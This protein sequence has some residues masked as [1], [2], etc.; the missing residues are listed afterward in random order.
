MTRL[1]TCA[2]ALAA[3]W[4]L[5]GCS[6]SDD[7]TPDNGVADIP[8][9]DES[10]ADPGVADEGPA[11]PGTPDEGPADPGTP[12]VP[13]DPGSDPGLP[14][15][16]D[17]CAAGPDS[18]PNPRLMGPFPVGIRTVT[19]TDPNNPNEDGSPRILKTEIWYPTTEEYRDAERY[20]YD[21]KADGT[22]AMREKYADIDIGDFPCDGVYDAPVRRGSGRFPL[23]VFSHGA[24][25]IRFQSVFYT[26][27]LASHGY[28]VIAPDHQLNTLYEIMV[29]GWNGA[30]LIP[31]AMQRPFDVLFLIDKFA[32]RNA[33]PQD[34]LY[35]LLDMEHVG[36]TGHSFGGLTSF[37]VVKDPR[38]KAIVPMAPEGSMV[39]AVATVL[40]FPFLEDIHVPTLMMGGVL[41]RTL[42]YQ[43]SMADV[44][45]SINPPKWFLTLNRGGHYTFTDMCRMKLEDLAELWG[46]AEDA[47]DDGCNPET[48]WNYLES[49]EATLHYA[50][51]FLNRYLRDSPG[52][53]DYLT[54]EAGADFGDEIVF[55][56]NP[57]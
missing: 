24:Y 27:H 17:F 38:V 21:P 16:D 19:Y 30:D 3:A 20:A 32:Q 46:D 40:E 35:D 8:A 45:P 15:V 51:A 57:E 2:L 54:A 10:P 53:A 44:Y 28:V 23:V 4:L 33:D 25:G 52:S 13:P 14:C 50:I 56:A 6:G 22:D 42:N 9:G 31:S 11:D 43:T 18:A 48:N 7:G 55:V 39:N 36:V 5:A 12:D 37:L 29:D 41:D 47:M 34:E 49:H 1:R 26:L